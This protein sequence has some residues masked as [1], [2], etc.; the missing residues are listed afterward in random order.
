MTVELEVKLHRELNATD[1][2][3]TVGH[4]LKMLTTS[5]TELCCQPAETILGVEPT[6][7]RISVDGAE[8][9]AATMVADHVAGDEWESGILVTLTAVERTPQSF[10]L[11][12][13]VA[14]A[15]A[16]LGKGVIVDESGLLGTVRSLSADS[17]EAILGHQSGEPFE[18]Y[19]AHF[20][21]RL[22]VEFG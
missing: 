19:A 17:M 16:R 21:Q 11:L 10:L 20:C 6:A 4:V 8:I 2:V 3:V 13:V 9:E 18:D 7:L 14:Y 1:L 15:L 12:A 22:H 5:A